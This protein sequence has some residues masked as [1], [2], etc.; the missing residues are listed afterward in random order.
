MRRG[1]VRRAGKIGAFVVSLM[2]ALI[3]TSVAFAAYT[4]SFSLMAPR[5]SSSVSTPR[6]SVSV[7]DKYGVRGS[8]SF[9]MK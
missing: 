2:L 7:Y 3:V 9:W 4:A 8:S 5:S 1:Q 6:V